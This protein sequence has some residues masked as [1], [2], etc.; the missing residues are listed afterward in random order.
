MLTPLLHTFN[1]LCQDSFLDKL[2]FIM[3]STLCL[4]TEMMLLGQWGFVNAPVGRDRLRVLLCFLSHWQVRKFDTHFAMPPMASIPKVHVRPRSWVTLVEMM[5]RLCMHASVSRPIYSPSL[6][7]SVCVIVNCF[8][9]LLASLQRVMTIKLIVL[10]FGEL[11]TSVILCPTT[12]VFTPCL[13]Y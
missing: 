11:D 6:Q 3:S 10:R 5:D 4:I 12:S 13:H 1:F 7:P 9:R 2:Q 8:D